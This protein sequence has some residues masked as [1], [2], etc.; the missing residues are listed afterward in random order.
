MIQEVLLVGKQNSDAQHRY[1]AENLIN[2]IANGV[3]DFV[4]SNTLSI[5]TDNTINLNNYKALSWKILKNTPEYGLF[6]IAANKTDQTQQQK[7]TSLES[8]T[9]NTR[10]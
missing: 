10:N 9:T 8:S 1:M 6:K 7:I 4:V 3:K 2:E 5:A